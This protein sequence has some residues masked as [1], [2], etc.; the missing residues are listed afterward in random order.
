MLSLQRILQLIDAIIDGHKKKSIRAVNGLEI[1]NS[2]EKNLQDCVCRN[3]GL[4]DKVIF[5][6]QDI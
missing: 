6:L 5:Y 1:A 3:G 2:Q 4:D